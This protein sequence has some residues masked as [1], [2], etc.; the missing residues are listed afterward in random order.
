M[1]GTPQTALPVIRAGL[2]ALIDALLLATGEWRELYSVTASSM[3][4]APPPT[5]PTATE[6]AETMRSRPYIA[7]LLVAAVTGMIVSLTAWCYLELVRN[8][9]R[10]AHSVTT[11]RP[12]R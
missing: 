11:V 5:E 4:E 3:A 8:P 10:Q 12:P 7:L 9:A 2:Y 1:R 6:A